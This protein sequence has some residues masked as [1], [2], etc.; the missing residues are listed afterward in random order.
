MFEGETVTFRGTHIE[1]EGARLWDLPP[2]AP[3]I[4]IACSGP[5]SA[6]LAGEMA[7]VMIAVQ[8]EAELTKQFDAAGGSG[9][10][11]VG[12]VGVS[13]DTDEAAARQPALEQEIGRAECTDKVG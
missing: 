7:D 2:D 5:R 4:G 8:P 12:P 13:Y 10:P 1:A 6:R 3:P 9:K 11:R